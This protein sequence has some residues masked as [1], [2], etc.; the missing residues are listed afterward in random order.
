LDWLS[1]ELV[2]N[3]SCEI[4]TLGLIEISASSLLMEYA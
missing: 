3:A 2:A 1:S 4:R